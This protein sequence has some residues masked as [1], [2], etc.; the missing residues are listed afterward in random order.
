MLNPL[1]LQKLNRT[2]VKKTIPIIKDSVL[3]EGENW[4]F[5]GIILTFP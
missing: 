5:A 2:L 4:Y 1:E 3:K